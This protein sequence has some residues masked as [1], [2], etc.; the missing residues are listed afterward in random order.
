MQEIPFFETLMISQI[1]KK[2]PSFYGSRKFITVLKIILI[3]SLINPV[4]SH[5]SYFEIF[6]ILSSNLRQ[7]ISSGLFSSGL[8][9]KIYCATSYLSRVV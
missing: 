9:T 7:S 2:F 8:Y 5:I 3:L 6:L 1:A 4:D